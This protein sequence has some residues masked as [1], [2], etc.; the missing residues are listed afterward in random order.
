MRWQLRT[1]HWLAL[2]MLCALFLR[3][4]LIVNGGQFYFP[5]EKRYRHGMLAAESFIEADFGR[6]I[7]RLLQYNNHHGFS[8]VA[9]IPALAHGIILQL[10]SSLNPSTTK[11]WFALDAGYQLPALLFSIPSV[12]CIGMIF[13]LARRAGAPAQEA[14]VA[15]FLLAASNVI[16]VFSKHFLPYDT[17]L[18]IG[19]AALWLAIHSRA[20]SFRHSMAVGVT[21][22]LCFWIYNGHATFAI[23]IASVHCIYH[24]RKPRTILLRG[25]AMATGAATLFLPIVLYNLYASN[26]DVLAALLSFST[27]VD[28]GDFKEGVV[29]PLLYFFDSE[30]GIALLWLLGLVLAGWRL[31]QHW[32]TG[33]Q[34]RAI[35]WFACLLAL[36]LFIAFLSAG[37]QLFVVYGRVTRTMAPFI[38]LVCAYAFT[39]IMARLGQRASIV[40]VLA[41]SA[42]ALA[43][44]VPAIRQEYHI[45]VARRVRNAY[46]DVAFETTLNA[47]VKNYVWIGGK[48]PN[49]RYLLLNA[50]YYYPLSGIADRPD[51]DVLLAVSHPFNHRPWQYEGLTAEMRDLVNSHEFKIWLID[52]R[53]D[54]E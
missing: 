20:A 35:L 10:F 31:R 22:F 4:L 21:I 26:V 47:P 7:D 39:P 34:E 9:F 46:N 28:Q 12:L 24:A 45:E 54:E 19:L 43:N 25:F 8:A 23:L 15:S 42:L 3:L 38:V 40:F 29:F 18:L 50:G 30:A 16:Y 36:Y 51:G 41:V 52:T 27:T 49:A 33:G 37:L 32:R 5:D 11:Y 1:T 17:S 6:G 44:F 53:P 48:R 14:L 2:I 13:L